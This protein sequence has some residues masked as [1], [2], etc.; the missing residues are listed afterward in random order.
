MEYIIAEKMRVPRH[1]DT[2]GSTERENISA[3]FFPLL[4]VPAVGELT[5]SAERQ[6]EV[7]K[8]IS[9]H[10]ISASMLFDESNGE[11]SLKVDRL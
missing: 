1:A 7:A 9:S 2:M 10:P 5:T 3:T 11:C 4:I 8:Y 6:T